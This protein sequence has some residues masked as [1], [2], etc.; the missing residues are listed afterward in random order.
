SGN[1][2]DGRPAYVM[3]ACEASLRRLG[4]D[5]IDLYFQHRVD[6]QVPIEETVGA[7]ARLVGQGK[8]RYI[9]LS[10]AA[11]DTIR[12]AHETH[13]LTAV[14]TEFSLLYREEA[15]ATRRITTELEISFFA[16]S[17]LG[18]SLLTGAYQGRE[19]LGDESP[20]KRHP[21]FADENLAKNVAFMTP[22]VQLATEKG[23][24]VSQL[25]LAWVLAQGPDVLPIPGTKRLARLEENIGAVDVMLS[26]AEVRRLGEAMPVGAAAGTRYPA[27]AMQAVQR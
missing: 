22:L 24:T 17:P 25:A 3:E 15:Q 23:C 7:M 4:V 10:E 11:P 21:R 18:R 16:Y 9:G 26:D 19:R 2:V 5:T 8:V 6:P 27:G 14:Q 12:R 1:G 13:P 20:H